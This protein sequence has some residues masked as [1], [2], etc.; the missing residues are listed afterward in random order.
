[1]NFCAAALDSY[2]Q[3]FD[4]LRVPI[5]IKAANFQS[6][7]LPLFTMII[8]IEPH[9]QGKSAVNESDAGL[10]DTMLENRM[11]EEAYW[12]KNLVNDISNY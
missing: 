7:F 1:L 12:R 11:S 3:Y 8:T 9:M 10:I 6:M 2:L 4:S 5:S